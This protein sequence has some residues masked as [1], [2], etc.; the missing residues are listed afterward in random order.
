MVWPSSAD[1]RS[2]TAR[3]TTSVALPAPNGMTA[4]MMCDGQP[5]ADACVHAAK[6]AANLARTV[7]KPDRAAA[8]RPAIAGTSPPRL[9]RAERRRAEQRLLGGRLRPPVL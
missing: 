1:I 5:C 8:C 6:D 9:P 4:L 2:K 7:A 3:G